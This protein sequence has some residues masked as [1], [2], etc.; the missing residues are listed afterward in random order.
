MKY[1]SFNSFLKKDV[2]R[3]LLLAS[4]SFMW[5]GSVNAKEIYLLPSISLHTEYDDNKRLRSINK[6]AAFG[7]ITRA[8]A[9]V[10]VRSDS[11]DIA[12]DSQVSINHYEV[13]KDSKGDV[14]IDS[15]DFRFDLSSFYNL[16][17]KNRVGLSANYTQDTTLTSEFLA[18]ANQDGKV[19]GADGSGIT[20]ERN[21]QRNKWSV[22]PD[23]SY[24]LSETQLLQANYSHT[25][26]TYDSSGASSYVDYA[27][28][29]AQISFKQQWTP[30][31]SNSL[32]VSGMYYE[33]PKIEQI[34][35]GKINTI[36]VE[37]QNRTRQEI[38]EYSINVGAEYQI[39]PTWFVSAQVG[40]RFTNTKI[41]KKTETSLLN[42][43]EPFQVQE[44]S[45]DSDAR[46]L[47][48]S[49]SMDKQFESGRTGLSYSRSTSAQGDG[50]LQL[51]D[52]VN[53]YFK[54]NFPQNWHL[55]LT[56]S[57]SDSSS[58]NN[59]NNNN[60]RTYIRIKPSIRWA[61]DRQTS[62]TAGYQ[63]RT[64]KY[65]GSSNS[66]R[67]TSNSVFL[68]LNYRWGKIATQRY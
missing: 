15:E 50:R 6:Y 5:T 24:S 40:Q 53:A 63:Y 57:Y 14:D 3:F 21:I 25:E 52:T 31:F 67:A 20:N 55:S 54:Y 37:I 61:F 29:F 43:S 7:V 56:G 33:V 48:F 9:E 38:T 68:V 16:T 10:G 13:T 17:E 23:W 58:A 34:G 18:D 45:S 62:L 39:S 2:C 12:L 49:F 66:E 36:D 22:S 51:R 27:I 8:N 32:S 11:Y 35:I 47:T 41:T 26:V 44:T 65:S 59:D 30:L 60:D 46:G 28:D 1:S 4:S 42:V 19:D 64:Q